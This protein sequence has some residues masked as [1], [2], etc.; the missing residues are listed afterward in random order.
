MIQIVKSQ[1]NFYVREFNEFYGPFHSLAEA[2]AFI[3]SGNK[4]SC[5]HLEK[6]LTA[7]NFIKNWCY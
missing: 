7:F 2:D 5:K 1:N 6:K 4:N 3:K